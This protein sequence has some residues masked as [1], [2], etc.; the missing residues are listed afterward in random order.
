MAATP[1][2]CLCVSGDALLICKLY[3]SNSVLRKGGNLFAHSLNKGR[4]GIKYPWSGPRVLFLTLNGRI[5]GHREEG[6]VLPF[7][8]HIGMCCSKGY[9]F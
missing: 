8:S 5:N 1:F 6:G 4:R 9:G 2:Y 7:M 3:L